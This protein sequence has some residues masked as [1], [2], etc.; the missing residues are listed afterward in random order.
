MSPPLSP[1]TRVCVIDPVSGLCQGC[2]RTLDEIVGW[3]GLSPDERQSIMT[4]L[5]GRRLARELKP[6]TAG[7]P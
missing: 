4:S 3:S 1:C 7:P 2:D 5:V 6:A